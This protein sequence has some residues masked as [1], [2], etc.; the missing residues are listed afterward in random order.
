[1]VLDDAEAPG[2][3]IEGACARMLAPQLMVGTRARM[4]ALSIIPLA[5]HILAH[6]PSI[7]APFHVP[8]WAPCTCIEHHVNL[9]TIVPSDV[10]HGMALRAGP[11]NRGS[12]GA[13]SHWDAAIKR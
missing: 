4:A 6:K 9:C 8:P 1:M 10:L 11:A 5:P 12:S 2:A 3:L 7:T 13:H